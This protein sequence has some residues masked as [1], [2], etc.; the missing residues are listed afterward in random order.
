MKI[1]NEPQLF[2]QEHI[3][4]LELY[5]D[6]KYVFDSTLRGRDGG[7]LDQAF[8]IFYTEKSHPEGSNY[9]GICWKN[10]TGSF[11]PELII[12][13][14]ISATEEFNGVLYDGEVYYSRYCHDFR[15]YPCGLFVDGGRDYTRYGGTVLGNCKIGRASCRERV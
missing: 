2:K 8:A 7:W 10:Y 12:T 11:K 6:G 5:Y 1:H 13:N 3:K 4:K 15:Q 9:F 14:G